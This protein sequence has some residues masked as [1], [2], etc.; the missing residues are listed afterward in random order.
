MS[1][2]LELRLDDGGDLRALVEHLLEL[3]RPA[4]A[5]PARRVTAELAAEAGSVDVSFGGVRQFIPSGREEYTLRVSVNRAPQ[6]VPW[7][8]GKA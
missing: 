8:R 5:D 2:E 4:I 7:A 1:S 6:P 3:V